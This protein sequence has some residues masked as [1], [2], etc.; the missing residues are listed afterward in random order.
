MM[1]AALYARFSTDR[2]SEASIPDQFRLAERLAQQHGFRVVARFSDAAISGGTTSRPGYQGLLTAARQHDFDVIVAEDTTRLWRNLAEQA[3]R[4][5]ELADLG[6]EVVTQDLDTRH[7]SADLIG[8]LNGAVAE[9]HR[10]EIGRRTRRGLEGRARAQKPTG[11][12][13]YGYVTEDGERRIHTQ[14]ADVVRE[15]FARFAAG[16][17]LRAI[18]SSL[19]ARAIPSPGADWRR[20]R[21]SDGLWRISALHAMLRNDLY[22]GRLIWNRSRW[23]RSA[24]DS[25]RRRRIENPREDWIVHER[26]DLAIVDETTFSRA[27]SRLTERADLFGGGRGGRSTYILSGLMRCGVCGGPYVIGSHRPVRYVCA[28]RRNAGDM[29]CGN[30][31]MVRRDIAESRILGTVRSAMLTPEARTLALQTMRDMVREDATREPPALARLDS[32]I[33]ELERLR[34]SGVLSAEIA[35]AALTRAHRDRDAARRPAN[36]VQPLFGA[37]DEY[38]AVVEGLFGVIEG[39]DVPV[40]REALRDILGPIRLHPEGSYLV[41]ELSAGRLPL[42]NWVGSGG[43]LRIQLQA[44]GSIGVA[45]AQ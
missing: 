16:E 28:T 27:Q 18:A 6:V 4:I 13:A 38:V 31:I 5:A 32:Q 12:R 24:A 45:S 10:R 15:L 39:D 26:P 43:S 34:A 33:A 42:V 36:I 35:G 44:T 14:Q 7:D 37:E 17:T 25:K 3:P 8:P 40:A 19:N 23:A 22:V 1:R 20:T 29:A 11:G 9:R 30:R 2:Q 41:A 21:E